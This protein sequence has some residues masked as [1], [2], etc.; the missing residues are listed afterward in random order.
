VKTS[1]FFLLQVGWEAW[2]YKR[3]GEGGF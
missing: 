1:R 2:K 3:T